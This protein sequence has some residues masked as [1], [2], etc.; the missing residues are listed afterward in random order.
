M[1]ER[2]R[3]QAEE[4][5]KKVNLAFS[6]LS[7]AEKRKA[8]DATISASNIANVT[9][10]GQQYA[11][12]GKPKAGIYP[13][14]VVIKDG[15]PYA[16]AKG[17]FFIRNAGGPCAKVLI[18]TPPEWITLKTIPMQKESKLPM[19]VQVEAMGVQWGKIYSSMIAVRLG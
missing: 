15:L 11:A 10:K 3:A 18:S 12:K 5:L 9:I 7:D 8:Y 16:K 6:I 1:S 17:C 14:V 4:D 13:K 2:I 19:R